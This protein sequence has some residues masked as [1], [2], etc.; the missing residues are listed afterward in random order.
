MGK[1]VSWL[2]TLKRQMTDSFSSQEL[3]PYLQVSVCFSQ[4]Q[5]IFCVQSI[6]SRECPLSLP[7]LIQEGDPGP[8]SKIQGQ[9]HLLLLQSL[10]LVLFLVTS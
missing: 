3:N 4:M 6:F 2:C 9:N 1:W 8:T 10:F 7:P 5:S